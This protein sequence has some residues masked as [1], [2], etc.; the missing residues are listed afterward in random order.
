MKNILKKITNENNI[1]IKELPENQ[2]RDIDSIVQYVRAKGISLF[3]SELF[4]KDLI[5]LY[6]ERLIRGESIDVSDTK[7]FCDSFIANCPKRK[8]EPLIYTLYHF[9]LSSIIYCMAELMSSYPNAITTI[10]IFYNIVA[11]LTTV[12]T[13]FLLPRFNLTSS[14]RRIANALV[15]L[16]LFL[17]LFVSRHLRSNIIIIFEMPFLIRLIIHFGFFIVMSIVWDRYNYK[18]SVISRKGILK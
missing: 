2:R 4:R 3:D 12:T 15:L 1:A 7:S 5:S 14:P 10:T 17:C 8:F 16:G 9:G 13:Y 6:F 18:L 11:L